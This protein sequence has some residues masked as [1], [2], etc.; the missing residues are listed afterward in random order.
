MKVDKYLPRVWQNS[1]K[2]VV[3]S[4]AQFKVVFDNPSELYKV[5]IITGQ[6]VI[7]KKNPV[8]DN[9]PFKDEKEPKIWNLNLPVFLPKN[10]WEINNFQ[11]NFLTLLPNATITAGT[12]SLQFLEIVPK[13]KLATQTSRRSRGKA[14]ENVAASNTSESESVKVDSALGSGSKKEAK[15]PKAL[16][17]ANSTAPVDPVADEQADIKAQQLNGTNSTDGNQTLASSK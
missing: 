10:G 13:K 14:T 5:F 12:K 9:Y 17:T 7:R 1:Q 8:P 6:G 2:F 11:Q 16:D 4:L 15:E 3:P